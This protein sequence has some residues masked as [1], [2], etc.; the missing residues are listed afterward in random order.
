MR[1]QMAN[2]ATS[3]LALKFRT[4]KMLPSITECTIDDLWSQLCLV[5]KDPIKES[6]YGEE[7]VIHYC[8]EFGKF[9]DLNNLPFFREWSD[10]IGRICCYS[11]YIDIDGGFQST[12]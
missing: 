1:F 4:C 2:N 6:C 5:A 3:N 10:D 8:A 11:F 7:E 9:S 12:Q